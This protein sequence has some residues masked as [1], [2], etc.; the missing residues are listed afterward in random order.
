MTDRKMNEQRGDPSTNG[1]LERFLTRHPETEYVDAL[2]A[3]LCGIIRCKRHPVAEADRI[4]ASGIQ[5]PRTVYLLDATGEHGDPGGHGFSDGDPDGN[6]RAIA[7]TLAPVPWSDRPGAQVLMN[8]YDVD[9]EPSRV[10]PRAVLGRVVDRLAERGLTPVVAFELEFY[11]MDPK[12]DAAGGPRPP[13]RV[14]TGERDRGAQ[15][16]GLRELEDFGEFLSDV[17]ASANV[18]GVPASVATREFAPGQY[19]IN[20]NHVEDPLRA[21]D[22]CMLLRHVVRSVAVRHGLRASFM[23]KPYLEENGSGMHVHVSMR[24]KD[25]ANVFAAEAAEGSEMLRH[26]IGGLRASMPEAMGLFAPNPNAFRRYGPNRFV[27]VNPSWAVNNRSVAFRIPIGSADSR[28]VEHR[29]S[30][31]DAN[32]YLVLAAILAG[33][34]HGIDDRVDPGPPAIGNAGAEVDPDLPLECMRALDRLESATILA[35][36]IDS[37]YLKTYVEAKRL[38]IASLGNWISPREYHFYL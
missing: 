20:L 22:H 11:L 15:V 23:S 8:L 30:G 18:Q 1:E 14:S 32:P 17:T 33:M 38:E 31:A 37:G 36:Y 24:G 10:D 35:R 4:F 25:G 5:I 28:R 6:A 26:A 12:L 19:E 2:F 16:Y 27:P 13:I 7:G 34:L 9:G 3:D 21:A 29:V